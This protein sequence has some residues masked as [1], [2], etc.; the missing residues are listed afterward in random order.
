MHRIGQDKNVTYINIA[1]KRTIDEAVI[2]ALMDKKN[3]AEMIIDKGLKL[4]GE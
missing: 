2:G 1:G 3:V 4:F